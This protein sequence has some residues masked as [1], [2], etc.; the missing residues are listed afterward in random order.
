MTI[1]IPTWKIIILDAIR[2]GNLSNELKDFFLD[3]ILN[4]VEDGD[5]SDSLL[6]EIEALEQ[7][8][9]EGAE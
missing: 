6:A 8:Y 5:I 9:L 1:T 3:A 4:A 2:A 7:A